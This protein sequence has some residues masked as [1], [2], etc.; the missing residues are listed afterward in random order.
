MILVFKAVIFDMDGVLINTEW[1]WKEVNFSIYK[2]YD[3]NIDDETY[4]TVIGR[5]EDE[6]FRPFLAKRGLRGKELEEINKK[7]MRE[8][9]ELFMEKAKLDLEMFP[10][11]I[12]K[13]KELKQKGFKLAIATSSTKELL[14]LVLKKF[15]IDL[16][17]IVVI[18]GDEIA[19]S[20]P[21]PEIYLKTIQQLNLKP[22]ECII[23]E[24]S[25]SGIKAAKAAGAF[26]IAV[27]TTFS[28]EKIEKQTKADKIIKNICELN[29][30]S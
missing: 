21:N 25:I 7:A 23:I 4:Q 11:A 24:D 12:E 28:K 3:I 1:L 30:V 19:N 17:F 29:Q 8:R 15:N 6:V 10:G 22:E 20:K 14:D 16:Y 9:R 26:C 2:K 13:I 18:P 5:T 27:A